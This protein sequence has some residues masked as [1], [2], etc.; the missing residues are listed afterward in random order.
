MQTTLK[1]T[2]DDGDKIAT[3]VTWSISKTPKDVSLQVDRKAGGLV[4]LVFPHSPRGRA[5]AKAPVILDLDPA[6]AGALRD[7]LVANLPA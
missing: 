7:W 1:T 4:M 3:Q 6:Q 2:V 5:A